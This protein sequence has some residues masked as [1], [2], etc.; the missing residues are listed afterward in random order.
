MNLVET[1]LSVVANVT[2]ETTSWVG[3]YEPEVPQTLVKTEKE[4]K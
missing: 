3:L 2:S 1:V 4:E